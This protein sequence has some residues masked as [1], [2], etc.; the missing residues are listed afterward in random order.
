MQI[1]LIVDISLHNANCAKTNHKNCY[2]SCYTLETNY[3]FTYNPHISKWNCRVSNSA[4]F[5]VPHNI[6]IGHFIIIHCT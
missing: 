5:D 1:Q 4:R 3:T 6:I 2:Y